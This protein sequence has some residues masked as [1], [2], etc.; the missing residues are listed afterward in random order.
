MISCSRHAG[1][2]FVATPRRIPR[3]RRDHVNLADAELPPAETVVDMNSSIFGAGVPTSGRAFRELAWLVG[4]GTRTTPYCVGAAPINAGDRAWPALPFAIVVAGMPRAPGASSHVTQLA[5]GA[6]M[7]ASRSSPNAPGS[8]RT[9]RGL[10]RIS[11]AR[12]A[13]RDQVTSRRPGRQTDRPPP[14]AGHA[15]G[16]QP[17]GHHLGTWETAAAAASWD[18]GSG[19]SHGRP[20]DGRASSCTVA[21]CVA[22][23]SPLGGGDDHGRPSKV[24]ARSEAQTARAR[25]LGGNPQ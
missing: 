10:A 21:Q 2:P 16:P 5:R 24:G 4:D 15:A 7:T 9:A 1:H 12:V 6:P 19:P 18:T 8:S 22:R 11:R 13:R 25:P 23:R 3:S 20:D 17:G 14:R